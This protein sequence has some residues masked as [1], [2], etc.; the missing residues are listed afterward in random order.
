MKGILINRFRTR[1]YTPEAT[2]GLQDVIFVILG[3]GFFAL[4]GMFTVILVFGNNEATLGISRLLLAGPLILGP[5]LWLRKKYGLSIK[6]LGLQKP[7]SG[8]F[9][10]LLLGIVAAVVCIVTLRL[11]LFGVD[12]QL[13]L[14]ALAYSHHHLLIMLVTP[15]GFGSIILTPIS[16]EIMFRGFV[17]GYL[18]RSLGVIAGLVVQ[19]LFFGALHFSQDGNAS[20]VISMISSSII[21]VILG[22]LYERTGSLLASIVCH[23]VINYF[24]WVFI[25]VMKSQ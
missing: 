17:Y 8:V 21:G 5:M 24:F 3:V 25:I 7:N 19:A 16:E 22:G 11:F 1:Q 23:G 10:N 20:V 18:R 13:V 6:A 12:R 14:R 9:T 15:N 2:W 4:G